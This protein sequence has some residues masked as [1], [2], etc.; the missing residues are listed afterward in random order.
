M[1]TRDQFA[2]PVPIKTCSGSMSFPVRLG[3]AFHSH[4]LCRGSRLLALIFIPVSHS[5]MLRLVAPVSDKKSPIW[6]QL[7]PNWILSGRKEAVQTDRRSLSRCWIPSYS[8]E[9]ARPRQNR[10]GHCTAAAGAGWRRECIYCRRGAHLQSVSEWDGW[11]SES[12]AF[13]TAT[14][15]G[16]REATAWRRWLQCSMWWYSDRAQAQSE[17]GGSLRNA[18]DCDIPKGSTTLLGAPVYFRADAGRS[19][20]W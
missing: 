5:K 2:N 15:S 20:C 12:A 9:T 14:G 11:C 4:W 10:K 17:R 8:R 1:P 18:T 19:T 13:C 6:D 7:A 3:A 16:C